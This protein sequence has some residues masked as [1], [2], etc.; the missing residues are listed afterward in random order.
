MTL[1]VNKEF[2]DRIQKALTR[3]NKT[4]NWISS[5]LKVVLFEKHHL[6]NEKE[7]HRWGEIFVKDVSD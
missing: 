1:G 4:I 7:S 2:W 3:K 5:K 6:E